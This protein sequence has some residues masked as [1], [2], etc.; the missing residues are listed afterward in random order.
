MNGFV[1]YVIISGTLLAIFL[2][3]MIRQYLKQR[4]IDRAERIRQN[5]DA[6]AASRKYHVN[7]RCVTAP[8][9]TIEEHEAGDLL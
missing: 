6:A 5:A 4:R 1:L 2:P 3:I 8:L 7:C 9:V